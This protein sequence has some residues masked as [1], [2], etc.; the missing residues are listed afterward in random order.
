M[1]L[2]DLCYTKW[3]TITYQKSQVK[4]RPDL[5][6]DGEGMQKVSSKD[7]RVLGSVDCVDPA[8]RDEEG[9]ACLKGNHSTF[10]NLKDAFIDLIRIRLWPVRQLWQNQRTCQRCS[11]IIISTIS[12][13]RDLPDLQRRC[14]LD[15]RTMSTIRTSWDWPLSAE[16]S[17][18]SS[19]L[20]G[21]DTRRRSRQ[22]QCENLQIDRRLVSDYKF[23]EIFYFF[24]SLDVVLY[25]IHFH[26]IENIYLL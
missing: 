4:L 6:L 21:C 13:G 12:V 3:V 15:D 19:F 1:K 18:R 14:L 20:E 11:I 24:F 5:F 8:G 23:N 7:E 9:R 17:R 10:F 25:L 16:W 22:S 26:L 2:Q